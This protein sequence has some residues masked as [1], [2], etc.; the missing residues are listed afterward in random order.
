MRLQEV[1]GV[2]TRDGK[3]L[4]HDWYRYLTP[5][6]LAAYVRYVYIALKDQVFDW[7]TPNHTIKRKS[8][9][10]GKNG[11][12]Q[13][14]KNIWPDIVT[15][16]N[17][18]NATPGIWVA[19]HLSPSF[20]AVRVAQNKGYIDGRPMLL[21]SELSAEVYRQYVDNFESAITRKCA[22]AEISVGS[23]LKIAERVVPDP[24]DLMLLVLCDTT[25]V[26]ATP[27]FR[28]AFAAQAECA[29]AV[30]RYQLPAAIEYEINQ[31]L[32]DPLLELPENSWWV[33]DEL[34]KVVVDVRKH[35]STYR[36]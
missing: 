7:D 33:S 30:S 24:D 34:K 26:N 8:W 17:R 6:Q 3:Y 23:Q 10:G 35:W 36:G 14:Q 13:N 15:A 9:D 29:R 28:H 11:Y 27:F 16:I 12:N 21:K 31:Y 19:A 1:G 18:N 22:A 20:H 4:R 2:A 32:Y 25:N 5:E